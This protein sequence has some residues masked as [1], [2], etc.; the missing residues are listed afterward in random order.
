MKVRRKKRG[1]KRLW[2][3]IRYWLAS[4]ALRGLVQLIRFIPFRL[5]FS[6]IEGIGRRIAWRFAGKYKKKMLDNLTSTYHNSLTDE[7]KERIAQESFRTMLTGFIETFYCVH[8][9][10]KKFDP[11]IVLE[12]RENLE[13]ALAL[14]KGALAVSAHLGTFTLLGAKLNASGFHLTWIMGGQPHPRLAQVWSKM[15]ERVGTGFIILDSLF[16]FHREVLRVLRKG[17][18]MGFICDENQK[19]GGVEVEFLGRVMALPVGPAVY[20]LKTG[21]PILPMFILRQKDGGHKVII[22]PP[23]EIQLSGDEERDI[24]T[25]VT[26]IARV[27]ESYIKKYPGQWSWI[28]KRRIR[29]RTRRKTFLEGGETPLS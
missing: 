15:G 5:T 23:L 21:A 8:F 27:M 7:E 4:V 19:H 11:I 3:E 10:D 16:R 22:A 12:G 29:T 17:E 2:W 24:F 26:E 9:Y 28:S 14:G 20:H 6:A 13:Q 25:I 1:W 18:I